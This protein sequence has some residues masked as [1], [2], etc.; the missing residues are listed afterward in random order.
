MA[1]NWVETTARD[2]R[3][4]ADE[5]AA[6]HGV[7]DVQGARLLLELAQEEL[8]LAGPGGLTPE[9]LRRLLLEV[10]PDTVVAGADEVPSILATLGRTVEFLRDA[11]ELD[12]ARA[13]AL[14]DELDRVAPE[15]AASVADT[16]TVERRTAAEVVTGLMAA[17]GVDLDD[18]AAVEHW[19]RDFEALP[20]EERYARTEEYLRQA[21][22]LVVPPVRLAPRAELAAAARASALTAQ[23]RALVAWLGEGRAVDEYEEPGPAD[24]AAAVEA[25]GL[26][27]PRRSPEVEDLSDLPELERLWWAAVEA[28]VIEVA[29]GTA[30]PGPALP[31]LDGGDEAVLATWLMLFDAAAVPEHD[32]AD[33]LDA[34]ELVQNEL[35]GVLIHLYEHDGPAEPADLTATLIDHIAESYE[36]AD[37]GGLPGAV[38]EALRLEL[39]DLETWGAVRAAG[40]G[41]VL[42]PLGVWGVRELLLADGFVAPVVGDLA[43]APAAELVA[44]LLWHRHDTA[45]EEITGW[46]AGRPA[47]RAAAELLAVMRDGGPGARNLA[48]GVLQRVG[49]EAADAVRAAADHP[50]VRPYAS[51]WLA[52]HG[53]GGALSRDEYVWVFIDTV[54]A[55]LETAEPHEAVAAALAEA[56]EAADLGAAVEGMWRA[57]HPDTAAVLAALGDHHPDRAVA[58]AARTAAYKA[59]SVRG[60]P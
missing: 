35:T 37:A 18:G 49:P 26:P 39:A 42:T 57:D 48:A 47:D 25:L 50:A 54:A 60:A 13:A 10:F 28:E 20:E 1:E 7:M 36:V 2:L 51:L 56:P 19:V 27:V 32:P 52:G 33:G 9:L 11:G 5:R 31:D 4:W 53:L 17:D 58:K 15:F 38:A 43:S 46:L 29:G 8:G 6:E 23:A 12:A 40:G 59:R 44:G 55:M 16:D 21:E 24:A 34:V 41:L 14:E 22:E 3:R 30:R 45:D